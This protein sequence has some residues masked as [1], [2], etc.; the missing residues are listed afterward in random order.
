MKNKVAVVG[1]GYVGLPVALAAAA[2]GYSVV[3]IDTN[4]DKVNNLL[5]GISDIEDVT[6]EQLI[7]YISSGSYIASNNFIDIPITFKDL[8]FTKDPS[9]ND[10]MILDVHI[11][12]YLWHRN[13][14]IAIHK[15]TPSQEHPKSHQNVTEYRFDLKKIGI[16]DI[17]NLYYYIF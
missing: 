14:G 5:N 6:S 2:S 13:I 11:F 4:T 16:P 10:I 15:I 17:K 8:L 12:N 1:Q 3:G 9:N 7:T